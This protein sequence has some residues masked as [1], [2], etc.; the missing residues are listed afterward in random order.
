[1]FSI[2]KW[3]DLYTLPGSKEKSFL[4]FVLRAVIS[5]L[6]ELSGSCENLVIILEVFG[7]NSA[8]SEM[9]EALRYRPR[10]LP[11]V[12]LTVNPVTVAAP[13]NCVV[14]NLYCFP[15]I[16]W[17]GVTV[18]M[19]QPEILIRISTFLWNAGGLLAPMDFVPWFLMAKFKLGHVFLVNVK[20]HLLSKYHLFC[21]YGELSV[22]FIFKKWS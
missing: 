9:Q 20:T 11:S 19:F 12:S 1:M 4:P 13:V 6:G 7:V 8:A 17:L 22:S 15:S 10:S 18:K 14:M 16:L 5:S 2:C 3:Y 21:L